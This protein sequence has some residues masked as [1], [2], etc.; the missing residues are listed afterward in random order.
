M[1]EVG[2]QVLLYYQFEMSCIC[3]WVRVLWIFV[4]F[5]FRL[6]EQIVP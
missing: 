2:E 3:H 6:E 5:V 4:R 1:R